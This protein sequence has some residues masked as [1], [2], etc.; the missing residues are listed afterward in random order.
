MKTFLTNTLVATVAAA[1]LTAGAAEAAGVN[2]RQAAQRESIRA[3]VADGS[4]TQREAHRLGR[5]QVNFERKEQRFRSDGELTRRERVNLQ[6]TA[7]KNRANIYRQ[8]HD[9][10][11]REIDE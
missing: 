5:Q 6:A 8:R 2:K 7:D 9:D 1:C 11:V 3:G 4:L 10:Q